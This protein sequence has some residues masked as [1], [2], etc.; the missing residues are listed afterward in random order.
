MVAAA[1]SALSWALALV[2]AGQLAHAGGLVR[3]EARDGAVP[4]IIEAIGACSCPA[5]LLTPLALLPSGALLSAGAA[6]ALALE[7]ETQRSSRLAT[8][9]SLYAAL[10]LI[11]RT[12][13]QSAVWPEL[14]QPLVPT[15]R[16]R[17][18]TLDQ[19]ADA[20]PLRGLRAS[21][22]TSSW[23]R[24]RPRG[25]VVHP[26]FA[27]D[28]AP[29]SIVLRTAG[30]LAR[31][32]LFRVR[33]CRSPISCRCHP[34]GRSV[35]PAP[36]P[37]VH[38]ALEASRRGK[39]FA[40]SEPA[41]A[42]SR[43]SSERI[44]ARLAAIGSERSGN[45]ASRS[46]TRCLGACRNGRLVA[47]LAWS[48]PTSVAATR[49]AKA[50]TKAKVVACRHLLRPVTFGLVVSYSSTEASTAEHPHLPP[51]PI[52]DVKSRS[53]A[54]WSESPMTGSQRCES[55]QGEIYLE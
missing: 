14:R 44:V 23:I 49:S 41:I 25:S 32:W 54:S 19:R 50:S 24:V 2:C 26:P 53:L 3:A 17:T 15:C 9:L 35:D 10:S 31:T 52:Q 6:A 39:S 5:S 48:S 51:L 4:L 11:A 45:E 22:E 7:E 29:R 34:R 18:D 40:R 47:A 43:D 12:A 20:R 27:W 13:A 36:R 30:W 16:A 1:E 42:R 55:W 37:L 46:N 38:A 21:A 28:G 33:G 8:S